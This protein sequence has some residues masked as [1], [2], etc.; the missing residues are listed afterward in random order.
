[1]WLAP[2]TVRQLWLSGLL[3]T[4]A[5]CACQSSGSGGAATAPAHSRTTITAAEWQDMPVTNLYEVVEHLHPEWL[6][7]RYGMTTGRAQGLTQ[8]TSTEVSVYLDNERA[9]NSG[10]LKGMVLGSASAMRYFTAAESQS[11]F[12]TSNLNGVIQV[13]TMRQ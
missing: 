6:A 7:Q 4:A 10:V 13:V 9:G 12:G 3:A 1:M 2:R 5:L 11:R 8:E